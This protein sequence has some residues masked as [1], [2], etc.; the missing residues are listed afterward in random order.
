MDVD[1]CAPP[2]GRRT[3]RAEP[4]ASA[5]SK[6]PEAQ[7][8]LQASWTEARAVAGDPSRGAGPTRVSSSGS[9]ELLFLP[10]VALGAVPGLALLPGLALAVGLRVRWRSLGAWPRRLAVGATL[11]WLVYG[12]YETYM[13]FWMKTVVAPIRVD[14]LLLT[15]L[16]YLAA[17]VGILALGRRSGDV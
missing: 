11:F 13:Y 1:R 7:G 8:A 12:V 4:M 3:A 2:A 17:V 10:V 5:A 9:M 15:P 16:L 6:M 14:L